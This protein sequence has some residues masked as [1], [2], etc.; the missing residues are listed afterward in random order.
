VQVRPGG[1]VEDNLLVQNAIALM[2]GGGTNPEPEGVTG[3]VRRNVILDGRDLQA[4]SPRGWGM[5]LLNI[6]QATIESNLI[7]HNVHGT[8]PFPLTFDRANGWEG[9]TRGVENTVYWN[10][11]VYAWNGGSRFTGSLE[12]T[13]NVQ[14]I[15]NRFQNEIT[16]DPLI[17]HDQ[18][19]STGGVYSALNLCDA[20]AAPNAWMQRAGA[21]LSLPQWMGFVNDATSTAQRVA[22]PDPSRTIGT[23]QL[24]LGGIPTVLAFMTEARQQSKSTW[25]TQYTAGAVNDYIRAGF[26]L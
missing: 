24:S 18:A 16:L 19:S 25:R 17:I 11:V 26:G 15:R 5:W 10:N 13:V 20:I 12:Q 4:G 2:F 14:L 21:P 22:F 1:L 3:T 8:W 9:N 6:T 23:Y 7:A